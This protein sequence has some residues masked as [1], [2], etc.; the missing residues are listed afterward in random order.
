MTRHNKM[1]TVAFILMILTGLFGF[2]FADEMTHSFKN[3]SFSGV[4]TSAH[5]L[6][7]E[8][9]E[10]NREQAI[11]DEIKAFRARR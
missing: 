11:A 7:I 8:N 6:T 5:Y 4:G 3:P 1:V 2:L 10:T 9:Q